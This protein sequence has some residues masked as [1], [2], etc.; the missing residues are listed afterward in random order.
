MLFDSH[1]HLNNEN[2]TEEQRTELVKEIEERK[3]KKAA[4]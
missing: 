2:F 1:A 4:K 3:A